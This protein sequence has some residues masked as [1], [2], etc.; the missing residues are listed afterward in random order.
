MYLVTIHVPLYVDTGGV[1]VTTEWARSLRLLRDSFGGRFGDVGVL[2]PALPAADAASQKRI[3]FGAEPGIRLFPSFDRRCRAREYWWRRSRVWRAQIRSLLPTV[4]VVHAGLDN[5]YRPITYHGFLE[6]LAAKKTTVFVQD[7]DIVEQNRVL[8]ADRGALQRL[9]QSLYGRLYAATV[10]SAV[11]RASLSLLKGTALLEKYGAHARNARLFH[12]TSHSAADIVPRRDVEARTAALRAGRPL[13]L[14]YCGR[15]EHRKG[16]R[17]AVDIVIRARQY[18]VPVE[19][20]MIGGGSERDS[21]QG[22]ILAAGVG[23]HVRLLGPLDYCPSFIARLAQYDALLF[24]PL[25]EDTPR[26]IFDGYAAGLPLI[27]YGIPYVIERARE[28][29]ATVVIPFRNQAA[30]AEVLRSLHGDRGRLGELALRALDAAAYHTAEC[31][32]TRRA[33]WT[34]EAYERDRKHLSS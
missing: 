18:G 26:M 3:L 34:L 24:T 16:V 30:G 6:G 10:R 13:R 15:L 2:A 5:L 17:D 14:A 31:W 12:D 1:Y 32:Y 9:K 29:Q 27:G 19:F 28:E 20:D 33:D 8:A 25:A 21:L 4:D 22:A 11:R 23:E 7:T